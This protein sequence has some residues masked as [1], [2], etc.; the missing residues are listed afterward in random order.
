MDFK[1]P[2]FEPGHDQVQAL[3]CRSILTGCSEGSSDAIQAYAVPETGQA[4]RTPRKLQ[5]H[6]LDAAAD[7]P[8]A[9]IMWMNTIRLE[10]ISMAGAASFDGLMRC[11]RSFSSHHFPRRHPCLHRP[12]PLPPMPSVRGP[13]LSGEPGSITSRGLIWIC[14]E[15]G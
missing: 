12:D 1:G 14:H 15:V 9:G 3:A 8:E 2:L 13:L 10:G 7:S 6:G 5:R 11:S 4:S